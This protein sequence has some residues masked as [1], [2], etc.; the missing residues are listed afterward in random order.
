MDVLGSDGTRESWCLRVDEG[1]EFG[2]TL[3]SPGG[4][5]WHAAGDDL[6]DAL[7][8][9]RRQIEPL[10]YLLL[11]NGAR[12]DVF[13]SNMLRASSGGW[14]VY[15][16]EK[17]KA[18]RK[19]VGVLDSA[20]PA[21]VGTVAEQQEYYESWLRSPRRYGLLDRGRDALAELWHRWRHR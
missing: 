4:A 18:A 16:L 2:I 11:C 10:G 5:Q 9:L 6:F 19:Q 20:D 13:P 7:K 8:G 21:E 3:T 15:V 1:D 12:V 17:G 14:L